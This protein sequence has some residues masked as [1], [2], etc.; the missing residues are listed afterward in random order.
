MP[1]EDSSLSSL[2]DPPFKH[3]ALT[4]RPEP[5]PALQQPRY[6]RLYDVAVD[7]CRI[8]AGREPDDENVIVDDAM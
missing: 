5:S 1:G 6:R 3:F 8:Y 7:S 2:S 4:P